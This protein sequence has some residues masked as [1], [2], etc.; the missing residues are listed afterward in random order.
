MSTLL[1]EVMTISLGSA[2]HPVGLTGP[3]HDEVTVEARTMAARTGAKT[4]RASG[5]R[6]DRATIIAAGL[7]LAES[8]PAAMLSIRE[9][10]AKLGTDPTAIYRHFR[11]KDELMAA[12][13]DDLTVRGIAA[14]TAPPED[15]RERLRQL[16]ANTLT[17]CARYPAV[18]Q[19]AIVLTTH[20]AGELDAIEFMLDAFSRAGLSGDDLVQHYALMASHVLSSA[21]GV[22]RA[23]ADRG[24]PASADAASPW[25]EGP[26]TV[27]PRTHPRTA[28]ITTRLLDLEDRELFALGVETIIRSAERAA[29]HR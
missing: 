28:A 7:E 22:A 12:L 3:W 4:A 13:L 23:R 14:V 10:G 19:E 20:G 9:L 27:D 17:L 5:K 24:E 6:L 18:G 11:S 26:L 29:Q 15:W 21:A 16:A 1:T 25:F 8:R 2:G